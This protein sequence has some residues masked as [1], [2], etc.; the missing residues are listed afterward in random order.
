M[1]ALP[2]SIDAGWT[3]PLARAALTPEVDSAFETGQKPPLVFFLGAVVPV[4]PFVAT[5][6]SF[7]VATDPVDAEDAL[8]FNELEEL[9]RCTVFRCGMKILE[10]SSELMAEKPPVFPPFQPSRGRDCRF[11]GDATAVVI[12]ALQPQNE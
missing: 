3:E 11:G 2:D 10:T 9:L 7:S 8:E 4:S 6:A 1:G 5:E 12:G